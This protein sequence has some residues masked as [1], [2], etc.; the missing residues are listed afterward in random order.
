GLLT[1]AAFA[2]IRIAHGQVSSVSPA[3]L[4]TFPYLTIDRS[5]G[6]D[7]VVQ[8][9]NTSDAPV[10]VRCGLEDTTPTCIGGAGSC[11]GTVLCTGACEPA[12]TPTLFRLRLTANQPI[13]WALTGGLSTGPIAGAA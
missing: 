12:H 9:T 4:L 8:L 1:V 6:V 13:G 10:E 7:T 2:P 3:A 5:A 11:V